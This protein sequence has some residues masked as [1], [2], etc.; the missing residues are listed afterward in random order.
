MFEA[1]EIEGLSILFKFEDEIDEM[2]FDI[3][4]NCRGHQ[5]LTK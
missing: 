4:F 2:S 3:F 5:P 1:L